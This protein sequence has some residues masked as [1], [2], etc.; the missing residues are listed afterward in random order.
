MG[1]LIQTKGTQKLAK[2]FND[3]F[4]ASATGLSFAQTV[5]NAAGVLL[6]DAFGNPSNDLLKISDAFIA[7]NAGAVWPADGNDFLYPSATMRLNANAAAGTNTLQF[8]FATIPTSIAINSAV[9]SLTSRRSIPHGTTVVAPAPVVAGGILTVTLS[10]PLSVNVVAGENICF[11]TGRNEQLVR[12]WR[13]YLAH[14]L[15]G[16]NHAAIQRAISSALAPPTTCKKIAFQTIEDTQKV[17]I[18]V[19]PLLDA[20]SEFDDTFKIDIILMTQQTTAP[21]PLDPQ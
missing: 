1:A 9:S 6:P 16:E 7:Q 11:T 13:W 8:A 21:D 5:K 4:D 12:R 10:Q 19:Q 15:K 3:R 14:D 18:N 17:L 2:L 20:T